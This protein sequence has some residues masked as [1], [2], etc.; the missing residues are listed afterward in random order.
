[1]LTE[2]DWRRPDMPRIESGYELMAAALE[3]RIS[4]SVIGGTKTW[5]A[6]TQ[7]AVDV[8]VSLQVDETTQAWQQW[9]NGFGNYTGNVLSTGHSVDQACQ[10]AQASDDGTSITVGGV[11]DSLGSFGQAYAA[12]GDAW[13]S[14]CGFDKMYSFTSTAKDS[15][16]DGPTAHTHAEQLVSQLIDERAA[17]NRMELDIDN[18]GYLSGTWYYWYYAND[19]MKSAQTMADIQSKLSDLKARFPGFVK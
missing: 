6:Y 10:Q 11:V 2:F 13:S 16:Q 14:A 12:Q 17:Y 5:D 7:Q 15:A 3:Q 9:A 1:M 19:Q 8:P 4:A 18:G